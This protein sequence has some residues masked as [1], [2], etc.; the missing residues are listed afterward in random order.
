MPSGEEKPIEDSRELGTMLFEVAFIPDDV[1]KEL[2]YVAHG[3]NGAQGVWGYTEALF[4]QA[5]LDKGV[6]R[7]PHS[8]YKE[9]HRLEGNNA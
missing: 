9:L 6:L 8:K 1:R 7:V 2:Q 5:N 3:A 4:F